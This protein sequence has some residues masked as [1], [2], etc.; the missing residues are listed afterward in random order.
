[1]VALLSAQWFEEVVRALS[2]AAGDGP[3]PAGPDGGDGPADGPAPVGPVQV[4]VAGGTAPGSFWWSGGPGGPTA[5]PGT[6]PDAAVTVSIDEADLR[7]LLQGGLRLSVGY[8]QGRVKIDGPVGG[9]LD[10]LA[11]SA[12]PR[13]DA[14]RRAVAAVTDP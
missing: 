2:D 9:V 13:F 14:A 12:G 7:S 4:V 3:G 8:M 1:M 11:C 6:H 10:L 5:G